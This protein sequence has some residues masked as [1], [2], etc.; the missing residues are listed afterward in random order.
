[1]WY[2]PAGQTGGGQASGSGWVGGYGPVARSAYATPMELGPKPWTTDYAHDDS[3]AS[4][5]PTGAFVNPYGSSPPLEWR[6]D[7]WDPGLRFWSLPFDPQLNEWLQDV[8]LSSPAVM[9]ARE[10]AAEHVKWIFPVF[11][12]G[13]VAPGLMNRK[14]LLPEHTQ[15]LPSPQNAAAGSPVGFDF[16]KKELSHLIDRMEDGRGRYFNEALSQADGIPE[17][18]IHFLGIEYERKWWTIMLMRCGLTIGNL[19]YMYYKAQFKRVR[20]SVLCPGLVPPFGP[21]RHPAFP[22][23]HAFLGHFIALLLLE[24]EQ[25]HKRFGLGMDTGGSAGQKP[26]W[27]G[28][29]PNPNPKNDGPLLWLAMRLGVNRERMGVHYP[30]D[31]GAGRQL[32]WGIWDEIFNKKSIGVPTLHH[33][34]ARA[35]AEWA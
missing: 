31:T 18:F 33:V 16:I 2:A 9:A 30:S 5:Y 22:S 14:W 32:A 25:V 20:P 8:D 24:I 12:A 19:V 17:Y 26:T 28:G 35:R 1:M 34:L 7:D 11:A 29:P 15:W 23:G 10:F 4:L 3:G 6:T 21:P 27:N 13:G